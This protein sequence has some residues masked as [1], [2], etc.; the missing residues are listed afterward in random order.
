[1]ETTLY[2]VERVRIYSNGMNMDFVTDAC[3][4]DKAYRVF[5]MLGNQNDDWNDFF[6]RIVEVDE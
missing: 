2:K 5:K 3:T 4:Y 6:Y 1:M